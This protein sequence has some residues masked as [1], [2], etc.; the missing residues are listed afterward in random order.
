[1]PTSPNPI[2][3]SSTDLVNATD[4]VPPPLPPIQRV[5]G[6]DFSGA[7]NSGKTAWLAEFEVCGDDSALQ[8]TG[9]SSLGRLAGSDNRELVCEFLVQ[10]IL[11]SQHTLWAM[12]FPFA[13]PLELGGESWTGQLWQVQSFERSLSDTRNLAAEF[14]RTIAQLASRRSSGRVR[15]RTD[16]ET[17]TPFDSYH[18]RIIYQT[19]HGMRDVLL[20]LSESACTA[21]L[22]FQ[23]EK[24]RS[25]QRLVVESCPASFLKRSKLPSTRYKQTA[26]RAPSQIHQQTRRVILGALRPRSP[27]T[28]E[29]CEQSHRFVGATISD[30]RRRLIMKDSGGDAIDAVL[31]GV[32][33][34][35]AVRDA[36]HLRVAGDDRYPMEGFVFV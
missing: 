24:V 22:P 11:A 5:C 32:G 25:A 6:V 9:L 26:G 4:D 13:L 34:W 19:F 27:G 12:D 30:H 21:I 35:N 33:G 17:A 15:R 1:M 10:R 16:L 8:L 31:A 23:Y 14:G 2:L 28:T 29:A 20:P 18:Y 36:D 3:T 7:R